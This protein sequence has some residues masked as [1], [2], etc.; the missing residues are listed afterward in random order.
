MFRD[1]ANVYKDDPEMKEMTQQWTPV[2]NL[3]G[4]EPMVCIQEKS[5]KSYDKQ[6]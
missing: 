5:A 6:G 1:A 4:D 3:L 2:V